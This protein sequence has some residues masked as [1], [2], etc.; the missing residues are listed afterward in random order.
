MWNWDR[1]GDS[2]APAGAAPY[3]RSAQ[4]GEIQMGWVREPLNFLYLFDWPKNNAVWK[5]NMSS[6]TFV[7]RVNKFFFTL[8][9]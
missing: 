3:H 1:V 8:T 9:H 5:D 4:G 2:H 6:N 7:G